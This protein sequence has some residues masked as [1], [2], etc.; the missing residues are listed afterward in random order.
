MNSLLCVE[1]VGAAWRST[2]ELNRALGLTAMRGGSGELVQ[3]LISNQAD[4]NCQYDL[5]R[6]LNGLFRFAIRAA[7]LG[8]PLRESHSFLDH[9]VSFTRQHAIDACRAHG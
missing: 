7:A 8:A 1:E 4:V 3:Q 2:A 5:A 6:E 9:C